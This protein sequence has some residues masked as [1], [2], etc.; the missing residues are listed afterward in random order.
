MFCFL[1]TYHQPPTDI[2]G[3]LFP[4][5]VGRQVHD[6][7]FDQSKIVDISNIDLK[8]LEDNEYF[9]P[10]LELRR[11]PPSMSCFLDT[12]HQSPSDMHG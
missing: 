10:L 3:R 12:C 11:F 8:N 9:L 2:H 1:D 6:C 7:S 5:I 4:I